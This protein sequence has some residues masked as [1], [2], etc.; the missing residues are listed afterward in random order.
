MVRASSHDSSLAAEPFGELLLLASRSPR[1][2]QLLLEARIPHLAEDPG[3][4]D[5]TLRPGP[6]AT[7]SHW[8]TALAFLK[9]AAGLSRRP[10]HSGVV[11]G[12]DTVCV[13][14]GRILGQP[15]D[16]AEAAWMLRS[17][18]NRPHEVVTGVAL[19]WQPR[20]GPRRRH[21]FADA[22]TVRIGSL[23][24]QRIG[25]YLATERWR[26]KAGAYNLEERLEAGWPIEFDGDP[27]TVVGLP[28]R[29]LIPRL[30]ELGIGA[31]AA[32]GRAA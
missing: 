32:G 19:T 4:D 9:A 12:S 11:L 2:R 17:F 13:L 20:H 3:V 1:R 23:G 29:R 18:E 30:R 14:D 7:P 24:E 15:R 22:S 10:A 25:E 16:R 5:G 31:A 28:M 8:V 21:L 27:T 6:A 26:G